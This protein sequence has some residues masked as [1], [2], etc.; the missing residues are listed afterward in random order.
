MKRFLGLVF[1]LVLAT[2]LWAQCSHWNTLRVGS[3]SVLYCSHWGNLRGV[4]VGPLASRPLTCKAGEAYICQGL[5]CVAGSNLHICPV[6][7]TWVVQSGVGGVTSAIGTANRITVSS[8]TGDV[9]FDVGTDVV[10]GAS[11]ITTLGRVVTATGTPGTV[12]EQQGFTF[13]PATGLLSLLNTDFSP[14]LEIRPGG[15]G[16]RNSAVGLGALASNTTGA[17]NTV[18]GVGA[19]TSNLDGS[20]NTAIGSIALTSNVEGFNNVA[21]GY[22][23]LLNNVTGIGNVAVGHDAMLHNGQGVA[24]SGDEN[25]AVGQYALMGNTNGNSN[26]AVGSYAMTGNTT[27]SRNIAVGLDALTSVTTGARNVHIGA[28][29]DFASATQRDNTVALGDSALVDCSNCGV[30]GTAGMHW[31]AGGLTTPTATLHL[32]DTTAATGVT[33]LLLDPGAGQAA[34]P[35]LQVNGDASSTGTYNATGYKVSTVALAST[36]LSD[37]AGLVRGAAGLTVTGAI[38]KGSGTPGSLADS[39]LIDDGT[40]VYNAAARTFCWGCFGRTGN[41][42][43]VQ[44]YVFWDGSI[45]VGD[46]GTLGA[47]SLNEGNFATHVKWTTTGDFDDTGGNATYT[48][49][50]GVGTL[51]QL[52]ANMAIVTAVPGKWYKLVGDVSTTGTPPVCTLT[53]ATCDPAYGSTLRTAAGVGVDLLQCKS[54]AAPTGFVG[55]CTSGAAGTVTYDNLVWKEV[56]G[57][58]LNLSGNLYARGGTIYGGSG[59]LAWGF[60][61]GATGTSLITGYDTAGNKYWEIGLGDGWNGFSVYNGTSRALAI[62]PNTGMRIGLGFG[63]QFGSNVSVTAGNFDAGIHRTSVGV[64][65][66]DNGTSGAGWGSGRAGAFL[67]PSLA[68]P[69]NLTV[70]PTCASDCNYTWTYCTTATLADGT[71]ET[72]CSAIGTTAAGKQVLSA[73]NYN[74]LAWTAV[75]GA[76]GYK[77]R[78]MVSGGTP[79]TVGV[80]ACTA[81]TATSCKDVGAAGDTTTTSPTQNDTG[82]VRL[83][84]GTATVGAGVPYIVGSVPINTG[85]ASHNAAIT[86]ANLYAA[87]PAGTY[88]ASAYIQTTTAS[89]GACTSS[90]TI[91]WTYNSGAKT[92]NTILA[93]SHAVDEVADS[94]TPLLLRND[95]GAN[96]TYAV[97]L[98][99]GG[100]DCT[101]AVYDLYV[102]LERLQ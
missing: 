96:I 47:E 90:V 79:A 98:T 16:L 87:A 48:H 73:T 101:N 97:D 3:V 64:I 4:G 18:V 12:T 39:T 33:Q 21:I 57:G 37:T 41:A 31:G 24:I 8:A 2:T 26:V 58:D 46:S 80:F 72:A 23:A 81:V 56:V 43:P 89:A 74:T 78:R 6:D 27:G 40:N 22:E 36:H 69:T 9:T 45:V 50:T 25:T 91:G 75:T 88:R 42:A 14:G 5:G 19:M 68:T 44:R 17:N 93:H 86:T 63:L 85:S 67:L 1:G 66:L 82:K 13:D 20:R 59:T 83:Y 102:V 92:A 53:A 84:E 28:D 11:G 29:A 30:F 100:G 55:S 35:V 95:A 62:T 34:T 52:L 60:R 61:A 51:T 32:Q 76:T 54:A 77:H 94:G 7:N 10:L 99:A 15:S 38:P 70:T 71:T 49:A 65:D